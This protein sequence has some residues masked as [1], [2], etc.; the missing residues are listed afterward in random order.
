MIL[1]DTNALLWLD[2]GHRRARS[3]EKW[4]GSLY[5]SPVSLLEIQVLVEAARLKLR[6]SPSSFADDERWTLDSPPSA[7]WFDRALS[8][9]W[10]HEPADRLITA[11]ALYRGWKLAT[12]DAML[13]E[14]LDS[15]QV[16]AL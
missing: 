14:H 1:L 10:T 16:L 9:S 3:L 2:A 5:V 6:R 4:A 8:L 12:A 15:R 7:E 11:H 13:I